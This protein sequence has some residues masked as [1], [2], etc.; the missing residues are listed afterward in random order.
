MKKKMGM[1]LSYDHITKWLN[2]KNKKEQLSFNSSLMIT[3]NT[4]M[5]TFNI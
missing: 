2:M 5:I 1:P 3:A 4:M